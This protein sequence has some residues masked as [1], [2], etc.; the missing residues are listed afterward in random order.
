MSLRHDE[1][2]LRDHRLKAL[3]ILV[4][5][6][7]PSLSVEDRQ[8]FLKELRNGWCERCGRT[9]ALCCRE[10]WCTLRGYVRRESF[11]QKIHQLF[12]N[13]IQLDSLQTI[14]EH[15]QVGEYE[16]RVGQDAAALMEQI[17]RVK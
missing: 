11:D 3:V 12:L 2:K 6:F 10:G 17:W 7:L 8:Q 9:E 14:I 4:D 5:D 15:F 1:S 13:D 16:G